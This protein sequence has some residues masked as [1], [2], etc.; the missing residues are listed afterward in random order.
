MK[1][2]DY[3]LHKKLNRDRLTIIHNTLPNCKKITGETIT[4]QSNIQFTI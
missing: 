1:C 2:D 3:R 4:K